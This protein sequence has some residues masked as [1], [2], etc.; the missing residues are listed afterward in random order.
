MRRNKRQFIYLIFTIIS[1]LCT[2]LVLLFVSPVKPFSLGF[3]TISPLILFFIP[4]LLF[5]FSLPSFILKS[6]KHGLLLS[7]FVLSYLIFRLTGLT[8]PIFLVLLLGLFLTLELLFSNKQP[9]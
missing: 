2:C 5:F 1:A 8:H 9:K 3:I 6:R 4:V 7:L